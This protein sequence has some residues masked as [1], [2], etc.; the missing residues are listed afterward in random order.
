M[1]I[2]LVIA[3]LV[4]YSV[5]SI[6][7]QLNY[8][9]EEL[10]SWIS[11]KGP[12]LFLKT[13]KGKDYIDKISKNKIWNPLGYVGVI[14]FTIISVFAT[15]F[16]LLS[17]Y[18]LFK[19]PN[20]ETAIQNPK[21]MLVIPGV[22]DFLPLHIAPVLIFSLLVAIVIHELGHAIYCR[23][24][25]IEI[26]SMGFFFLFL[27]PMGAF[28]KPDP[29]SEEKANPK[30]MLQM[31]CAGVNMNV[32]LTIVVFILFFGTVSTAISTTNGA[33]V[34]FV[35]QN[36][37]ASQTDIQT[38]DI[39]TNINGKTIT[40]S[41]Q[42]NSFIRNNNSKNLDITTKSGKAYQIQRNSLIYSTYSDN[43]P[44][45][46]RIDNANGI[47]NPSKR[48]ILELAR[49]SNDN[50]IGINIDNNTYNLTLG[51]LLSDSE[52]NLITVVEANGE[53]V[54]S[55]EEFE[56]IVESSESSKLNLVTEDNNEISVNIS[57]NQIENYT[58]IDGYNG[59]QLI[60]VGIKFYNSERYLNMMQ[61]SDYNIIETAGLLVYLPLTALG[62]SL[63]FSGFSGPTYN[64]F[65][66]DSIFF[67]P[68]ELTAII[69][70]FLFWSYFINLNLAVFNAIP[71]FALDGGHMVRHYSEYLNIEYEE[72]IVLGIQVILMLLLLAI[73]FIPSL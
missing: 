67:L 45:G 4:I 6:L 11:V 23:V 29:D 32:I 48:D 59:L 1:I 8:D 68:S 18:L 3:W 12:S 50:S 71:T 38:G 66:Y 21:N 31:V 35:V 44:V 42:A 34:D 2:E 70:S 57:D 39:V 26:E 5:A 53:G 30:G 69:A 24:N 20:A 49:K 62:A 47:S 64:F 58:A 56:S 14:L 73:V 37:S 10:P 7:V 72:N 52:N 41:S 17:G 33:G 27:I 60:D 36:S 9:N 54:Y 55:S 28:V 19:N 63:G 40:N 65:Q 46:S 25:D 43:I 22:N 13:E 15:I 16:L 61:G 51:V